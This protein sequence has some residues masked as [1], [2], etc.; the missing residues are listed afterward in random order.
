MSICERCQGNGELVVDWEKYLHPVSLAEEE[1]SVIEC[2]D[3]HGYG[4]WPW[5]DDPHFGGRFSWELR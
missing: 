4:R 3:C 1:S 2:P 5:E